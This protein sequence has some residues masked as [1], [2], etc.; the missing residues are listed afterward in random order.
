MKKVGS[1]TQATKVVLVQTAEQCPSSSVPHDEPE[2][3]DVSSTSEAEID[4]RA[5]AAIP[6]PRYGFEHYISNYVTYA[7][8]SPAYGAFVTSLQSVVIP[9]N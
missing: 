2:I 6:P 9:K 4:A 1:Q 3:I 5:K 8:L 7:S